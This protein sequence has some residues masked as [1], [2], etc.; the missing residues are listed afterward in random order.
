MLP[1]WL[2]VSGSG[3]ASLPLSLPSARLAGWQEAH[4]AGNKCVIRMQAEIMS[5][6]HP[7]L[8][9][10]VLAQ[11]CKAGAEGTGLLQPTLLL[12]TFVLQ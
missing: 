6:E 1:P 11:G 8:G 4:P 12:P 5:H 10:P 3:R 2:T 9:S 7:P